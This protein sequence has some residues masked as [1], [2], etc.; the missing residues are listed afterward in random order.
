MSACTVC[1]CVCVRVCDLR[2]RLNV[3]VRWMC[4][5]PSC[6]RLNCK[7][8]YL[9]VVTERNN[10]TQQNTEPNQTQASGLIPGNELRGGGYNSIWHCSGSL[11][12]Q[13]TKTRCVPCTQK[14]FN[15]DSSPNW[16][17]CSIKQKEI[18]IW[19]QLETSQLSVVSP[20]YGKQRLRL[21]KGVEHVANP[22]LWER[23]LSH[24]PSAPPTVTLYFLNIPS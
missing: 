5:M 24:R 11:P 12:V 3:T 13:G 2:L 4:S 8:L 21:E 14:L 6:T 23:L 18:I 7:M 1:V 20:R 16:T 17:L 10:E 19:I 22:R 9:H 15:S